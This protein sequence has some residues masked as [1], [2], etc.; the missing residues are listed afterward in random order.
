MGWRDLL[1][2]ENERATVPWVGG[3][4]LRTFDR[5]WQINGKLPREHG[6][7]E[8]DLKGREAT[9]RGPV[10]A[11]GGV[12]R[13]FVRGYLVGDRIV[14]DG[15]RV[16][17]EAS[18]V[19]EVSERVHLIELGLGRFVRVS[20]GR[21]FEDGPLIYDTQDFPQGP[22]DD[23]LRAFQDNKPTVDSVS[24]VAPALDAA[25]RFETWRRVEA[26]RIRR[27]E[28]E[29]RE[30]E[31]AERLLAEKREELRQRLGDGKIRRE[32]AKVDFEAAARAALEVGGA[33]YLDHRKSYQ[34]GEMVVQFRLNRRRFECTC[35]KDTLRIIDS[36]I[37][38]VNHA[39]GEKGDTKFTLESLPSVIREAETRGV[40]VVFRHV[41]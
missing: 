30:H 22:E 24:G 37:C 16:P 27:E 7:C 33:E 5:T 18:G 40:L 29:R 34:K 10:E 2:A 8:F 41:D 6:W 23:V 3:R 38:L 14:P 13:D 28:Q 36:G 21:S 25:F 20:A 11:P 4:S 9:L 17:T 15:V 12:L 32:M 1:Q 39:T 31:E 26:E 35:D 19:L